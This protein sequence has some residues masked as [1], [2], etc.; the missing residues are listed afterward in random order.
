M[1]PKTPALPRTLFCGKCFIWCTHTY[2]HTGYSCD[3]CGELILYFINI[4]PP[5]LA[6]KFK[7]YDF[8]GV[9]QLPQGR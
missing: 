9:D 7:R 4:S 1:R 5:Q 8:K 2:T 6:I 3:C